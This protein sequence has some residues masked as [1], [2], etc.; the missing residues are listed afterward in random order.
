MDHELFEPLNAFDNDT[1]EILI[2]AVNEKVRRILSLDPQKFKDG[3]LPFGL[4]PNN[5]D[6]ET[7]KKKLRELEFKL[8]DANKAIFEMKTAQEETARQLEA[9]QGAAR[10]RPPPPAVTG[11]PAAQPQAAEAAPAVQASG[12]RTIRPSIPEDAPQV[13]VQEDDGGPVAPSGGG[14]DK[15]LLAKIAGLEKE[16]TTLKAMKDAL[17]KQLRAL[18]V[19]PV[20]ALKDWEKAAAKIG[21]PGSNK[22]KLSPEEL[23]LIEDA[24]K[25]KQEADAILSQRNMQVEE[26]EQ[27]KAVAKKE[28]SQPPPAEAKPAKEVP[29][30]KPAEPTVV[31]RE[32]PP[33]PAEDLGPSASDIG[34]RDTQR[35]LRGVLTKI[36]ILTETRPKAGRDAVETKL[37]RDDVCDTVSPT[38]KSRFLEKKEAKGKS[39]FSAQPKPADHGGDL[40]VSAAVED[41]PTE[42]RVKATGA[43]AEAVSDF[44]SWAEETMTT[45]NDV[46]NTLSGTGMGLMDLLRQANAPKK[47]E[48]KEAPREVVEAPPPQQVQVIEKPA[49]VDNRELNELRGRCKDQQDEIAKLLLTIDELRARMQKLKE[50][51]E[52]NPNIA[53]QFEGLMAEVGLKDMCEAGSSGPKLRGVFERLYQDA[54]QRVQRLGLIRER[55][56]VA[57]RAYTAAMSAARSPR[58]FSENQD[59][60][61]GPRRLPSSGGLEATPD[62]KKLSMQAQNALRGM[63]YHTEYLF[64]HSCEYAEAQ[65]VEASAQFAHTFSGDLL[66]AAAELDDLND[67]SQEL[68]GKPRRGGTD[69][70][71]GR[72]EQRPQRT[73]FGQDGR[74]GRDSQIMWHSLPGGPPPGAGTMASMDFN[75]RMPRSPREMRRQKLEDPEPTS[76]TAYVAA[77]RDARGDLGDHEWP[78][79]SRT[80]EPRI[81]KKSFD[82][83]LKATLTDGGNMSV[84]RSLPALPKGRGLLLQ[85]QQGDESPSFSSRATPKGREESRLA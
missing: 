29:Q 60:D 11:G 6:T 68:P 76:F 73:L 1:R 14:N 51:A 47:V 15:K 81:L 61:G 69:R 45:L 7:D 65:G 74:A 22:L 77:L 21:G 44:G 10:Q 35:I 2:D 75:R 80:P 79:C 32:L 4:R 30:E 64:R 13:Q 40:L 62:L 57:N 52:S 67:S 49:P 23:K 36:N 55:V 48:K 8:R 54:M 19:E 20:T 66:E 5:P 71:P 34:M 33:M 78:R 17:E 63:W 38:G 59:F 58:P 85:A 12:R 28:K 16:N 31:S 42:Y 27:P 37:G 82:K 56:A 84:S 50:I 41:A 72:R 39:N 43:M 46:E 24:K 18:G 70:L 25:A 83:S 3:E 9:A 26:K 53:T